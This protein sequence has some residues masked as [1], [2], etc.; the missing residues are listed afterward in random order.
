VFCVQGGLDR[1]GDARPRSR[2]ALREL[3]VEE[4]EGTG[5]HRKLSPLDIQVGVTWLLLVV[6]NILY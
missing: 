4:Y 6:G 2:A 3:L 5:L 1:A